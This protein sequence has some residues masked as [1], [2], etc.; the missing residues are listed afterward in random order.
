MELIRK[1]EVDIIELI[2]K[3]DKISVRFKS[4]LLKNIQTIFT[5]E[6]QQWYIANLFMYLNYHPTNEYPINLENVY[7]M[8]G[9]AN[10]GNAKRTLENNFTKEDDYKITILPSEKG[11]IPREE[12]MLNVDTFKSLCMLVKTDKGKEIRKYYVKLEN[13]V[14]EIINKQLIESETLLQEQ[15]MLLQI[16]IDKTKTES[17]LAREKALIESHLKQNVFYICLFK[18]ESKWYVKFGISEGSVNLKGDIRDR[19]NSH[20]NQITKDLYLVHVIKIENCKDLE[21]RFKQ[22]IV[23]IEKSFINNEIKTEIIELNDTITIESTIKLAEKLSKIKPTFNLELELAKEQT[24]QL[25]LQTKQME[26]QL[27]ILKLQQPI[28]QQHIQP[29]NEQPQENLSEELQFHKWLNENVT[30]TI[31]NILIW[32]NV[33]FKLMNK[34]V[35]SSVSSKYKKYFEN[36][37]EIKFPNVN[38]VTYKVHRTDNGSVRGYTNFKLLV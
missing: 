12:I 29:Q 34:N 1:K 21:N 30:F 25:E 2:E 20:K 38:N 27:E 11:Q 26:I 10:K 36:W 23:T 35:G 8:I 14:N 37:C 22:N 33:T 4:E 31:G 9:F 16:Q 24:R 6:Q 17:L 5:E 7:K 3:S 32:K 28:P 13:M 15:K 18:Y 19:I